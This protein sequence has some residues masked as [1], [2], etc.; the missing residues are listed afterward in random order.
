MYFHIALLQSCVHVHNTLCLNAPPPHQAIVKTVSEEEVWGVCLVK[1]G[2]V[3][4]MCVE[5]LK[6]AE[7]EAFLEEIA[8]SEE[9]H[10][11][12]SG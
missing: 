8:Q 12:I 9:A 5:V 7:E 4:G 3:L 1:C 2:E 6:G 11:K 10:G